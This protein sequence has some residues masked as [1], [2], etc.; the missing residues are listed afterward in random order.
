MLSDR[1]PAAQSAFGT[2]ER[3]SRCVG[4]EPSG[5]SISHLDGS[6]P[7]QVGISHGLFG[8]SQVGLVALCQLAGLQATACRSGRAVQGIVISTGRVEDIVRTGNITQAIA[9]IRT[10]VPAVWSPVTLTVD[11]PKADCNVSA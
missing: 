9:A 2:T 7:L 6:A 1:H 10:F 5:S 3:M 11:V 8:T 4:R